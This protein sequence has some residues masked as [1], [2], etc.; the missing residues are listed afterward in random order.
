MRCSPMQAVLKGEEVLL[1]YDSKPNCDYLFQYGFVIPDNPA[2]EIG[3][4]A[5]IP[6]HAPQY[7]VHTGR[8]FRFGWG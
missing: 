6:S 8:G 5:G 7:Q 1:N 4:V 3:L 2:D